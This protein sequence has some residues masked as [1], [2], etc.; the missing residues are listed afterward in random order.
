MTA[1]LEVDT[2]LSCGVRFEINDQV[3]P[4]WVIT[5]RGRFHT[6]ANPTRKMVHLKCHKK[7]N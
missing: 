3:L 4:V 6:E 1:L 5:H 7:E 2:C